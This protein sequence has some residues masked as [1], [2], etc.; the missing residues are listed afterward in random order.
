MGAAE[1]IKTKTTTQVKY[2]STTKNVKY[3]LKVG[4]HTCQVYRY[5]FSAKFSIQ[6]ASVTHKGSFRNLS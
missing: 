4:A 6:S 1:L 3:K 5:M 2:N